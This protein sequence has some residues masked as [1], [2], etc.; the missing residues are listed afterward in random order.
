MINNCKYILLFII[1]S[2]NASAQQLPTDFFSEVVSTNW[3][4]PTGLT[5]DDNGQMYVWQKDGQVFIVDTNGVRQQQP[6]IDIREEIADW[7]DHGLLGFTLHPDFL[8]N[9]Y[10]YL[11][12]V[13]DNHY[14]MEYGT[15]TYHPDSTYDY[16]PSIGRLTRYTAD[17]ATGFTTTIPNSRKVLMGETVGTSMVLIHE[18]HGVGALVFGD[19][20]SLLV[21]CGD[22]ASYEGSDKGGD[23]DG[24]YATEAVA[25]GIINQD[26]NIGSF[27][28]QYLGSHNGKILRID[29]ENGNGLPSNPFY[30]ANNPR[31]ARS[32]TY[33][34]GFRNPFRF[35]KRPNTGSH[36]IGDGNPGTLY[37]GDVGSSS[38]EEINI[39]TQ[40]GLNFGWPFTEGKKVNNGF[41][42]GT[43]PVNELAPNPLYGNGCDEEYFKFTD[44][45]ASLTL[46][47]APTF[48][49]PC[50]LSQTIPSTAFPMIETLPAVAWSNALWNAPARAFITV[51]NNPIE[52]SDPNSPVSGF[53]FDG[54]SAIPGLFYEGNVFPEEYHGAMFCADF[55]G[56]IRVFRF[57]NQNVLQDIQAF[58]EPGGP[59]VHIA[60]NPKDGCLYYINYDVG[61]FKICYGGTP[62]PVAIIDAD[63]TYGGNELTVQFDASQSYA[64]FGFP[65]SFEWD[66]GDGSAIDTS[67]SPLHTFLVNTNEVTSFTVNLTVTDSIGTSNT[68]SKIISL[69]NTPP[70]VEIISFQ[71]G[72]LYPTTGS[73]ILSLIAEVQDDEHGEE[74]L[75]YEWQPNLHHNTHFHPESV[76]NEP[77]T[78]A[79][80]TP[81]GCDQEI[82]YY[83]VQ[84][85]VT[86]AGGLSTVVNQFLYPDCNDPFLEF[87][88]FKLTS[89]A[90]A[91]FLD[92]ET[93]NEDSI[94]HY[95]VQRAT[96]NFKFETIE[97]IEANNNLT[98]SYADENPNF[99]TNYYRIKARRMNNAYLYSRHKRVFYSDNPNEKKITVFPNPA[100]DKINISVKQEAIVFQFQLFDALGQIV[101]NQ[102]FN[103]VEAEAI[104]EVSLIGLD[105]GVYF[106]KANGDDNNIVQGKVM[107]I[108]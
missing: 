27:R 65:I 38:Y 56:W 26:E 44:L 6:L 51:N 5:F 80:I 75:F 24:S 98:Y 2:V 59:L 72:D 66:F 13:V 92:W 71:D 96:D 3:E 23:N 60:E 102:R 16:K 108:N 67:T 79:V 32:R 7:R 99:G 93:T 17:I 8:S 4:R 88:D 21:S 53:S 52:I 100:N 103:N 86:D 91:V 85:K 14:L 61:I 83:R 50:D 54:T 58:Y 31:S 81:V 41:I 10:Y 30:D 64:P 45:F 18:S 68:V 77:K 84:L 78:A 46:G 74:E 9:G 70:R 62:K 35:L 40:G 20:G 101:V 42:N 19:D 1:F 34:L 73:S 22:G 106:F 15:A 48:R 39:S 11:L 43:V 57:D 76:S 89:D 25:S 90:E 105:D 104:L 87:L 47:V 55:N 49:N 28:S 94:L 95:E 37:I 29:P 69:N 82:Y 33:N 36:Y 12:Y 107:V 97:I 63:T